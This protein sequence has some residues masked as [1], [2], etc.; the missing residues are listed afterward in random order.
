MTRGTAE[1]GFHLHVPSYRLIGESSARKVVSQKHEKTG[2]DV[3]WI[4]AAF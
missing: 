3:P 1:V 2:G 4:D